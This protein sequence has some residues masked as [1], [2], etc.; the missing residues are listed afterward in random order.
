MNVGGVKLM[1]RESKE[2]PRESKEETEPNV[3]SPSS[4]PSSSS[5]LSPPAS[6]FNNAPKAQHHR[7]GRRTRG[8]APAPGGNPREREKRI[9]SKQIESAPTSTP[10]ILASKQ[11]LQREPSTPSPSSSSSDHS[12]IKILSEHKE[13]PK[14]REYERVKV[15]N[16]HL[17]MNIEQCLKILSDNTDFTV[18]GVLGPQSVG[19]STIMSILSGLSSS[20]QVFF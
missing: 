17:E 11:L 19:K 18:V 15:I 9:H 4:P 8:G 14:G 2:V 6:G 7:Y 1:V 12:P 13:T 10:I 3:I 5:A 20:T 16:E